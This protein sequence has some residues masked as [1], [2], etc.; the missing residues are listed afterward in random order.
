[1][2]WQ[3]LGG[4]ACCCFA[5][6]WALLWDLEKKN[7]E[8]WSRDRSTDWYERVSGSSGKFGRSTR[9]GIYQIEAANFQRVVK[10]YGA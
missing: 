7:K 1:M 2:G 10:D 5:W 3:V 8:I 6:N 4:A 9:V